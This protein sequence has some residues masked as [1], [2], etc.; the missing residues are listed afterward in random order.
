M[1]KPSGEFLQLC[2]VV[3]DLERELEHWTRT[4]RVGP[5][6]H[7]PHF[8]LLEAQYRGRRIAPDLDIALA[9]AGTT[10]IELLRQ[11]DDTPSPFRAHVQARGFGFQHTAVTT[12]AFDDTLREREKSGM[13]VVGSATVGL[14][15]RVAYLET[16]SSLGTLLELIE[17]TPPVEQFFG[18]IRAAAESWDG[19]DPVRRLAF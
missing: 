12:G 9:F 10:C 15:G 8:P 17:I 6:F 18:M 3:D 2:F 7:L 11:N 5:F 1:D 13:S 16:T 19:T 14:G 4:L